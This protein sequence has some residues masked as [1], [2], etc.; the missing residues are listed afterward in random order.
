MALLVCLS[1][2]RAMHW[3]RQ[4]EILE[5]QDALEHLRIEKRSIKR[6]GP[7]D[8]ARICHRSSI[9]AVAFIRHHVVCH[10]R[11][12]LDMKFSS[13]PQG[14]GLSPLPSGEAGVEVLCDRRSVLGNPFDM[15][16]SETQREQVL[17]AYADYLEA[18]L[19]AANID[20]GNVCSTSLGSKRT[21][22]RTYTHTCTHL[23]ILWDTHVSGACRE[24]M[25]ISV[26]LGKRPN[27]WGNMTSNCRSEIVDRVRTAQSGSN[28]S[29]FFCFRIHIGWSCIF[30]HSQLGIRS[31]LYRFQLLSLESFLSVLMS[32]PL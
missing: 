5:T 7:H 32:D 9:C 23:R 27:A 29:C 31:W 24:L 6:W 17:A 19:G 28:M 3:A 1:L 25:V 15:L 2:L 22:T 8:Q 16:E 18:V 30:N 21:R 4:N 14:C 11:L 12:E 10:D 26:S 20:F 13:L